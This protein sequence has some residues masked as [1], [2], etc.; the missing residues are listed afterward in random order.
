MI[1]NSMFRIRIRIRI[2]IRYIIYS[3]ISHQDFLF[4]PPSSFQELPLLAGAA[5]VS[6]VP[7]NST[8]HSKIY[9]NDE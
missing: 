9:L 4:R 8:R 6:T 3:R 5:I 1:D 2:R 7:T